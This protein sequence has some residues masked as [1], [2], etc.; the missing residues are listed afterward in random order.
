MEPDEASLSIL[1]DKF[2]G[3][4]VHLA[5]EYS[6]L[7]RF[8]AQ[9]TNYT[10]LQSEN[11][12]QMLVL[13]SNDYTVLYIRLAERLHTL[14]QLRLLPL[15]VQEKKKIAEEA[16]SVYAPLAHR[17]SDL[18]FPSFPSSPPSSSPSSP[19][20]PSPPPSLC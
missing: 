15:E 19:S 3:D 12:I 7:P 8:L 11:Q 18:I 17:V 4:A 10:A 2:G 20:L 14:R 5:E 9:K 1:K 13:F 16:R 6:R